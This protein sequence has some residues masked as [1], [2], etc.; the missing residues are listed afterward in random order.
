MKLSFLH[1]FLSTFL[2]LFVLHAEAQSKGCY[3]TVPGSGGQRDYHHSY[4]NTS[5][6]CSRNGG[7]WVNGECVDPN[8]QASSDFTQSCAGGAA[9][10]VDKSGKK[11]CPDLPNDT[12]P[13]V[14]E[15]QDPCYQQCKGHRSADRMAACIESCQ[16]S[17]GPPAPS[18]SN[19][20]GTQCMAEFQELLNKC[21]T[22]KS[23]ATNSCDSTKD[24]GMNGVS[25]TASQ[26]ALVLG[27][28]TSAST[29]LACSKMA[30]LSQ[31][32][33][34]AVLAF[35]GTCQSSI[36]SCVSACSEA[37]NY[38]KQNQA[39]CFAGMS[40]AGIEEQMKSYMA[41]TNTP[42]SLCKGLDA[43]VQQAQMAMNN[44]QQT[45]AAST[46]CAQETAAIPDLCISNPN[47]AGC[48]NGI[49]D[50]SSPSMANDK[51]C[52]CTKNPS[53]P[54]CVT[55]KGSNSPYGGSQ[56]F[57]SRLNSNSTSISGDDIPGL[58]P[59]AQGSKS[60]GGGR[61]VDGKVGG[62]AGIAGGEGGGGSMGGG[63]GGG[64]GPDDP[65]AVTSG[66]YG[67][68]G[69]MGGGVGGGAGGGAAGGR[70]GVQ[71]GANRAAGGPDLRAFLP[72]GKYDPRQ[73]GLAGATGVDGITG[74]HTNIWK[75]IQNRYQATS[76]TLLP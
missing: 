50:C 58:D 75:K 67:A 57:S 19:G 3:Y 66:F 76:P 15:S 8:A 1:L 40:A 61:G 28:A 12:S 45:A 10:I 48:K 34:A 26:I 62:G 55:A 29:H 35:Q 41:Q 13:P 18:D 63:S 42:I 37:Q 23:E 69:G 56:D 22:S 73:R 59:I 64:G 44:I 2:S 25:S 70:Y 51:V 54:A 38:I 33:N 65:T 4:C 36:G 43:K 72:G 27:Q 6:L 52:I 32:A 17:M 7:R 5:A 68:G 20:V 24:Q 60:G 53:D 71:A 30:A 16:T 39:A 31:A 11:K 14:A 21:E 74:P 46:A 47:L 49:V 9:P